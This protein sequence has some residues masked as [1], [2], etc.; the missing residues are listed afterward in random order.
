MRAGEV[1]LDVPRMRVRVGDRAVE[2]TPTEF[3]LLAALARAPG[4]IFTRAQLLDAVHGVAFES[5]ER[6]ID[7]HVKNIRRKL[8]PDPRVAALPAHRLRRRLPLRRRRGVSVTPS[9]PRGW[10]GYSWGADGERGPGER[11]PWWPKDEPFP[12]AGGDWRRVRGRF[13][14]RAVT[15]AIGFFL[16]FAFVVAAFV[17]LL[18]NAFSATAGAGLGALV[19]FGVLA[20]LDHHA[21]GRARH[22]PAAS[23]PSAT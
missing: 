7:A 2:L 21:R 23:S 6:A 11:P 4:R 17:T 22:P 8:E 18:I 14:R 16:L 5:Y 20:A 10:R 19:P 13:V 1:T 3:Q 12:P 15:F 9:E